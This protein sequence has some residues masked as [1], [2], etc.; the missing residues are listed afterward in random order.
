M[1]RTIALFI[2]VAFI[3]TVASM[4]FGRTLDEEKAAVRAY[5]KVVDAK[6]IKYRNARNTAKVK[7]M[8]KEKA[9]TLARWYKLQAK[10]QAELVV[11]P[12]P[13]PAPTPAP[14]APVVIVPTPA[15]LFGWG[16]NTDMTGSY[17]NTGKGKVNGTL[18]LRADVVLD[19]PL[20]LGTMV[21]LQANAIKY[22]VGL[23]GV[24]GVDINGNR[25]KSIPLYADVVVGLP[26][27]WMGGLETYIGGGINYNLYGNQLNANSERTGPI[28][29]QAYVGVM[30]DL[31][32]G[33]K[34]GF[35]IGYGAVRTGG[36]PATVS[37]KGLML[38]VTQMITL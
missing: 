21:G 7:V 10:M 11:P 18:A 1:K 33:G 36:D 5:L 16:L 37:A 15:G 2:A 32:L 27:D 23:G 38:S 13:P 20:A 6:I 19:D 24:Y 26:A 8:Q 14:V 30:A 28:G 29:A 12:P 17:I 25:I 3:A 34:T 22:K 9:G 35:E 31:G 4:A